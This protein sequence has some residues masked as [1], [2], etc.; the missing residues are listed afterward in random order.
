MSAS[1]SKVEKADS[2]TKDKGTG[3]AKKKSGQISRFSSRISVPITKF[4]GACDGLK[5][6]IY[7]CTDAKQA[8]LF[9]KTT[10]AISTYVATNFSKF[11]AD[12]SIAVET[13]ALPIFDDP[14][15]PQ[16]MQAKPGR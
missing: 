3:E 4:E 12:I 7:N 9:I 14:V 13:L 16:L 6:H 10:S 11:G 5:G 2:A 1:T 8:D 15:D